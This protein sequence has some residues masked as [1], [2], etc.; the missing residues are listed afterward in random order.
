MIKSLDA[1]ERQDDV[2]LVMVFN[3]TWHKLQSKPQKHKQ[4]DDKH[5]KFCLMMLALSNSLKIMKE[6]GLMK[7]A[8]EA[9]PKNIRVKVSSQNPDLYQI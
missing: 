5:L 7:T 9:C 3:G 2:F 8:V 4:E 1:D 6:S